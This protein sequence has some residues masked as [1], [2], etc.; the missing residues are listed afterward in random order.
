M[1]K[2]RMTDPNQNIAQVLPLS[3]APST[4]GLVSYSLFFTNPI[5]I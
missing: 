3:V 2:H 1:G 5:Y 4:P